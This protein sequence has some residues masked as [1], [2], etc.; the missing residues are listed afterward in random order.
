M[1]MCMNTMYEYAHLM[2]LPGS[3]LVGLTQRR[4]T[5]NLHGSIIEKGHS[6]TAR[7]EGFC[8]AVFDGLLES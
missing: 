7:L 2:N 5:G 6:C 3:G 4:R 1:G 8:R